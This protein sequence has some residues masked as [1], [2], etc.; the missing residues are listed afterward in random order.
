M[1]RIDISTLKRKRNEQ[2]Q[3][4]TLINEIADTIQLLP[5]IKLVSGIGNAVNGIKYIMED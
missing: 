2:L 3:R 4:D 5:I 1:G